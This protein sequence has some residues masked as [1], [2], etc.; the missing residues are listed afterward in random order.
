MHLDKT[1]TPASPRAQ[2]TEVRLAVISSLFLV[3]LLIQRQFS[4]RAGQAG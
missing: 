1:T 4:G 2:W 3:T